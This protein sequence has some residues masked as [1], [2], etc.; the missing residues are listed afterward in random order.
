MQAVAAVGAAG[1][2]APQELDVLAP[3]LDGDRIILDFRRIVGHG[4]EFVIMRRKQRQ[5]V[6]M[7]QAVFDNGPG[8]GHAIKGARPAADFIE[9]EQAAASRMFQDVRH[10]LHFHHERTLTG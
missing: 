9:D 2:D 7:L 1:N 8:D 6:D 10:F 5:G 3:F 4:D